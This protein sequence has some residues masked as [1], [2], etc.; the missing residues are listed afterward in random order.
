MRDEDGD[1]M[2]TPP[3]DAPESRALQGDSYVERLLR[4]AAACWPIGLEVPPKKGS[5]GGHLMVSICQEA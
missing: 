1:H 2:I 3:A 4:S 5:Q